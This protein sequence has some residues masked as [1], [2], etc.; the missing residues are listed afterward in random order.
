MDMLNEPFHDFLDA[1]LNAANQ[2]SNQILEGLASLFNETIEFAFNLFG[3]N[4]FKLFRKRKTQEGESW[5]WFNRP[6]TAVYDP[7]MQVLSQLLGEKEKLI[8]QAA[9]IRD[10]IESMYQEN[11]PIFE[12][13]NNNKNNI[14]ERYKAYQDF[15][16]SYLG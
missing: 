2:F 10:K 12:G 5:A 11:Y 7:L 4:A 9:T 14:E 15:L 3:D 13:R 16:S 1:Y 6:T 8:A